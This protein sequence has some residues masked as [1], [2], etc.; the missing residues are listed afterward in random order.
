MKRILPIIQTASALCI[1]GA[2][3]IWAPVCDGVLNLENGNQTHMNCWFSAQAG[4][5]L[6]IVMLAMAVVAIFMKDK[7]SRKLLQVALIVACIVMFLVFTSLIGVCVKPMA[8]HATANWV[9]IMCAIIAIA[10]L[11]DIFTGK[12]NQIP[13]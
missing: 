3:K 6:G 8:C 1:L 12:E 13:E 5:A 10:G 7:C 4:L 9:K 2:I 11:A